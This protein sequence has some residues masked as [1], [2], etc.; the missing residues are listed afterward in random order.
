MYRITRMKNVLVIEKGR[1]V[2]KNSNPE[3]RYCNSY[4]LSEAL[5]WIEYL[6]KPITFHFRLEPSNPDVVNGNDRW[7][8]PFT[9]KSQ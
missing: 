9:V 6:N 5:S 1:I 8:I 4:K 7:D 3:V 2:E